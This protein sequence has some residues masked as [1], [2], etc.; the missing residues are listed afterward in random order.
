MHIDCVILEKQTFLNWITI[1]DK[2][3]THFLAEENRGECSESLWFLRDTYW[4][5]I[6]FPA[7][8]SHMDNS[9]NGLRIYIKVLIHTNTNIHT[10]VCI[11]PRTDYII[12]RTTAEWKCRVISSNI[13]KHFNDGDNRALN[14]AQGHYTESWEIA[15]IT[16]PWSSLDCASY[17]IWCREHE[18]IETYP[19]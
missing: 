16:G 18:K 17:C 7:I 1:Y 6:S 4:Q 9:H 13:I 19:F 10:N 8:L 12:C 14:Q 15:H 11:L 3:N 5:H 2:I